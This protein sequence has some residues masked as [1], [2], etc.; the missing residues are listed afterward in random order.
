[1]AI[2]ALGTPASIGGASRQLTAPGLF[3]QPLFKTFFRCRRQRNTF[4]TTPVAP[5][6]AVGRIFND[7]RG[8]K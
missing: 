6:N 3:T 4:Y 2:S 7:T 5:K 8:K 1:M